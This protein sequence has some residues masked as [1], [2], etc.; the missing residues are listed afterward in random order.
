MVEQST[1]KMKEELESRDAKITR[2]R[3]HEHSCSA[4]ISAALWLKHFYK[5]IS[6]ML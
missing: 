4:L 1:E 6:C 2:A 5:E 3:A